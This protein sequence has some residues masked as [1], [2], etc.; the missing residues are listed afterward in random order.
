MNTTGLEDIFRRSSVNERLGP[1]SVYQVHFYIRAEN[2]QKV[3]IE[4]ELSPT[5]R[6]FP[7]NYKITPG[8]ILVKIG[9]RDVRNLSNIECL[10]IIDGY[11]A[12]NSFSIDILKFKSL[13]RHFELNNIN[14]V[15]IDDPYMKRGFCEKCDSL[16]HTSLPKS[17]KKHWINC[18]G[19]KPVLLPQK[20]DVCGKTYDRPERLANH[21]CK[22][23][24][25]SENAVIYTLKEYVGS[26]RSVLSKLDPLD[27]FFYFTGNRVAV[28]DKY[29]LIFLGRGS[30]NLAET[31]TLFGNCSSATNFL[32]EILKAKI[33]C[34]LEPFVEIEK[35]IDIFDGFG[36]F[37][38]GLRADFLFPYPDTFV[39][40]DGQTPNTWRVSLS[41]IPRRLSDGCMEAE[42]PLEN[43]NIDVMKQYTKKHANQPYPIHFW[44]SHQTKKINK[45]L[46]PFKM[47]MQEIRVFGC[48]WLF[49]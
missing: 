48:F 29:P 14:N 22:R 17:F 2:R 27:Q 12:G 45:H 21:F 36:G 44:P 33:A 7:N 16:I 32:T 40:C 37:L 18:T 28:E 11:K 8:D 23:H 46:Y 25:Q 30:H 42:N 15:V 31:A 9:S 3:P 19:Q 34:G 49:P 10:Q 47:S 39:K 20:C 24:N 43:L 1:E 41:T 38:L 35:E 6:F 26:V 13:P 5:K 4:I